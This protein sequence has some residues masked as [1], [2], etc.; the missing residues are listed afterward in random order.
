MFPGIRELAGDQTGVENVE[1]DMA[2]D[3]KTHLEY[4]NANAV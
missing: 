1:D 3:F 4:P 2:N